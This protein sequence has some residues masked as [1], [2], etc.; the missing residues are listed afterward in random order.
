MLYD[1]I[2]VS[3]LI[4]GVYYSSRKDKILEPLGLIMSNNG[5]PSF[6]LANTISC[7]PGCMGSLYGLF[8]YVYLN[9]LILILNKNFYCCVV[10]ILVAVFVEVLSSSRSIKRHDKSLIR[11]KILSQKFQTSVYI[12]LISNLIVTNKI[13]ESMFFIFCVCG[14]CFIIENIINAFNGI[15]KIN[16]SVED[17]NQIVLHLVEK[18]DAK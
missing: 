17:L 13:Y 14:L 15:L 4:F 18:Q 7:C 3:L 2:L 6:Y 9:D 16:N 10:L 11:V 8:G 5:R 12:L 1:I